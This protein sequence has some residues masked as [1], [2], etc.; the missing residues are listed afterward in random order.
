MSTLSEWMLGPHM[1]PSSPTT[2]KALV[3][4]LSLVAIYKIAGHVLREY[5]IIPRTTIL[6][7][8][9]SLH[10]PRRDGKIPGRVVVCGG[11]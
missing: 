8:I 11:R 4:A 7:D 9:D 1:R 6:K 5:I 2:A 3:V 10:T